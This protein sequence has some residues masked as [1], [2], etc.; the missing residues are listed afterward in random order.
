M[1]TLF[2]FFFFSGT[3]ILDVKLVKYKIVICYATISTVGS[4]AGIPHQQIC[5]S[6]PPLYLGQM[7]SQRAECYANCY[8]SADFICI[9]R[10]MK[11]QKVPD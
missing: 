9:Y 1:S 11:V 3:L 6:K 8:Y 2:F 10:P 5:W 4:G 7:G